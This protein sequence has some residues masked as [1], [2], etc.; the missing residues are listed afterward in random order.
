[1]N[2]IDVMNH[3]TSPTCHIDTGFPWRESDTYLLCTR[4]SKEKQSDEE[5]HCDQ[6]YWSLWW[7]YRGLSPAS[8]LRNRIWKL[9]RSILRAMRNILV[10]FEDEKAETPSP[11]ATTT[12]TTF[13]YG[14]VYSGGNKF[15]PPL[16]FPCAPV[17]LGCSSQATLQS[18]KKEPKKPSWEQKGKNFF[19]WAL[20][21]II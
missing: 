11:N 12:C 19:S 21:H 1:M 8:S 5:S 13:W 7:W 14:V 6:L 20:Q 10:F 2:L 18:R 15:S 17:L 9:L 4:T 3:P 16:F